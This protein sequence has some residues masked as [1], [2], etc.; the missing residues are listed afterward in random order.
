M[1]KKYSSALCTAHVLK[2]EYLKHI[3]FNAIKH[4]LPTRDPFSITSPD[5]IDIYTCPIFFSFSQSSSHTDSLK[6]FP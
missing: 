2:F 5:K 4:F 6:R 3:S 1:G